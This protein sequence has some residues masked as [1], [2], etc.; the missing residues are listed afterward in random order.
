MYK[1]TIIF[2]ILFFTGTDIN[3]QVK[4]DTL[5]KKLDSLSRKNDSIGGQKK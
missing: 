1:L 4:P 5:I 3:A 2:V